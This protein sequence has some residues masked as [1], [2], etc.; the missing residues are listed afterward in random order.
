LVIFT[1]SITSVQSVF[2]ESV[3][4]Q[5]SI[6]TDFSNDQNTSQTFAYI[7]QITDSDNVVQSISFV[8]GMLGS[9]QTLEQT[10]SWIPQTEGTFTASTFLWDDLNDPQSALSVAEVTT[11]NVEQ[12]QQQV[13]IQQPTQQV[14]QTQLTVGLSYPIYSYGDT[15]L[16]SGTASDTSPVIIRIVN[17]DGNMVSVAQKMPN[18]YGVYSAY[19]TA[20]GPSWGDG[21]YQV[22]VDN[23]AS[24]VGKVFNFIGGSGNIEPPPVPVPEVVEPVPVP[25]VVEPEPTATSTIIMG[26]GTSVPGCEESD[27]CYLPESASAQQTR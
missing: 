4:Q 10:L 23:G 1:L 25:E 21:I 15:I 2:A 24:S 22:L 9:G 16:I 3:N 12:S 8:T 27:S 20:A 14:V 5:I 17:Q 13:Q 7:L 18:S 26:V 19:F 6:S 11:I